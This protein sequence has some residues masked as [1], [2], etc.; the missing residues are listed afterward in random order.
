[1]KRVLYVVID[2]LASRVI[3]PAMQ[4]GDLPVFSEL[5]RRG[6]VRPESVAIFPS[7]TPAATAA[8]ATGAWPE[9]SGISGAFWYEEDRDRV[10]YYGDDFWVI[11]NRGVG[12]YFRDFLVELNYKRLRAAPVFE[13]VE[14]HGLTAAVINFMWFRGNVS[15]E[16]HPPLLLKLVAGNDYPEQI[17]GPSILLLADFAST[18]AAPG[19][20]PL[21]ASGGMFRRYGFHDETTAEYLM[22][23]AEHGLPD[24][25]V[26]YF[27][28]NDYESHD[29]GP[30]QSLEVV[31]RVDEHLGNVIASLGGMD[32]FLKNHAIVITGDHGQSDLAET[33]QEQEIH[34]D[35]LLSDFIPG[36]AGKPWEPGEEIMS[37]PN[38]R[39]AQIYLHDKLPDDR[40]Q[41]LVSRLLSHPRVDQV[42]LRDLQ[43]K[44]PRYTVL[45]ADRG[46]LEFQRTGAGVEA[47]A[48]DVHGNRWTFNG[49]LRVV[50]AK[51]VDGKLSY[52]DYPNALERIATGFSSESASLWATARIGSEFRVEETNL[53]R[54]GSH[55]S[56]HRDDSTSPL[57]IAG[58]PEDLEIPEHPR[59]IDVA[60]LILRM[61]EI[62]PAQNQPE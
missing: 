3:G 25:T 58:A 62:D 32:G 56:L 23:L 1:M 7:I 4:R 33:T 51:V 29:R 13:T 60:P 6:V 19:E 47:D 28:N 35:E 8:L 48:T 45:S 59:S 27:P 12:N 53:H 37:C 14:Q 57:I 31:Q 22:K 15:H 21:T 17:R 26:A 52:G 41:L 49:D 2:A 30:I 55:G 11:L 39:A 46:R 40:V 20:E 34:L 24:L 43:C 44:P 9:Q 42:I 10:A 16:V 18:A 38:M 5:A 54:G 61:L 36:E 50:D